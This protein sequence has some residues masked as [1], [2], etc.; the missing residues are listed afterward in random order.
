MRG[1]FVQFLALGERRARRREQAPVERRDLQVDSQAACVGQARDGAQSLPDAL[2]PL[3]P[4]DE[5]P[6]GVEAVAFAYRVPNG[7]KR[8]RLREQQEYQAI[9]DCQRLLE[10]IVQ[11]T[12]RMRR[13]PAAAS[14]ARTSVEA[15]STFCCSARQTPEA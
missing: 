14:A 8:A 15:A 1:F 11:V 4:F 3:R 9:H 12:S 6:Q 2:G 10:R 5:R 7:N 13:T